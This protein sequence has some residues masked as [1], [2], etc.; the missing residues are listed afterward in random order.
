MM[1]KLSRSTQNNKLK[2]TQIQFGVLLIRDRLL[3]LA[4]VRLFSCSRCL[5][6]DFRHYQ[7]FVERGSVWVALVLVRTAAKNGI[8]GMSPGS[9]TL[10]PPQIT[11]RITGLAEI[12]FCLFPLTAKL[13][14]QRL[15]IIFNGP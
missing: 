7:R 8:K 6:F 11:D 10:S 5:Y 15:F 9:T 12:F 14:K 1:K 2:T 13:G 3:R 4:W